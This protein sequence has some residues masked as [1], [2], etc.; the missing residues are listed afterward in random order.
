MTI[1]FI[2]SIS[3]LSASLYTFL[4]LYLFFHLFQP[5][6]DLFAEFI[7]YKKQNKIFIYLFITN[8]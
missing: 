1:C 3:H 5:T 4:K 8:V 7:K 6:K 2:L